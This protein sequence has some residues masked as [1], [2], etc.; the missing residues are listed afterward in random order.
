MIPEPDDAAKV[1]VRLEGRDADPREVDELTRRLLQEIR[2]R[3][4]VAGADLARSGPAPEHGKSADLVQ[5]GVIV[6]NT[7]APALPGLVSLLRGWAGRRRAG[8]GPD[9]NVTLSVADRSV[10][11]EYP[12]GSMSH[13]DLMKM[14]AIVA[15]GPSAQGSAPRSEKGS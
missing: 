12:V 2:N 13:A 10:H 9:V 8:T 6:L 15:N 4:D 1:T 7:L 5:T 14:I 11:L 3:T